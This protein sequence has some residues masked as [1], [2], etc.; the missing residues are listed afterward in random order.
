M[1]RIEFT[2]SINYANST[3]E[4]VV[5]N[6]FDKLMALYDMIQPVCAHITAHEQDELHFI[7]LPVLPSDYEKI[8]SRLRNGTINAYNTIY[9][10]STEVNE[11]G[12]FVELVEKV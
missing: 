4:K 2:S 9:D 3:Q 10:V 12:I 11:N 1:D 7:V 8:V 6:H 5:S